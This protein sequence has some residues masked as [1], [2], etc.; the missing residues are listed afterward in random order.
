MSE[1]E[2]KRA[3][4]LEQVKQGKV[5]QVEAAER[6]ELSYRQTKR[7]YQR[8]L[9]RGGAGLVHGNAGKRSNRARPEEVQARA[10]E[11]VRAQYSGEPGERF[12]PTL[13]AEHLASEHGITVNAETLRRWLLAAGLWTRERRRKQYRRRRARKA[14]FG[15]LLQLDGS[16]H[17]WLEA[18]GERGCLINLIDDATGTTLAQFA[19]EETTWAVADVVRAWVERYGI[20]RAIYTDWKNVYHLQ[21]EQGQERGKSQF[22]A[23]CA[24]L[25]IDLIAA[26]SPQAKGRVERGHGTHQDRLVKKLRRLGIDDY[27]K[28][29]QY[30]ANSYLASHNRAY[31]VAAGNVVDF[32]DRVR[33]EVNLDRVFCLEEERV[34]SQDW[35]VRYQNQH[36]Q[37]TSR[38]AVSA[39]ATVQAQQWRDGSIHL[40][41]RGKEIVYERI[42]PGV[43]AAD[44]K[45]KRAPRTATWKPPADHPWR[46]KLAGFAAQ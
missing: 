39:G 27:S 8:Y 44:A 6:L 11:L 36:M 15:E 16:F 5:L 29:N 12:G 45:A 38:S 42:E 46:K 18:R 41:W 28:A 40:L 10:L 22:G 2:V 24:K 26:N 21:A 4:I 7:L 14:H 17:Q 20:P 25:G 3:G 30:L 33:P 32:H 43:Q 9:K 1:A 23:M 34:V 35:V 13:A 19:D 37:L 31:A